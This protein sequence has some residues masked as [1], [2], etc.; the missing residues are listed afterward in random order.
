MKLSISVTNGFPNILIKPRSKSG[1]FLFKT[2]VVLIIFFI[3]VKKMLLKLI[4][5]LTKKEY[6]FPAFDIKDSRNFY[7]FSLRLKSK[8]PEGEYTYTLYDDKGVELASS[9]LQIGEYTPS[10]RIYTTDNNGYKCYEG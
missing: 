5:N 6:E 1:V 4:H 7:H 8:M 9:L 2:S 3:K 10:N